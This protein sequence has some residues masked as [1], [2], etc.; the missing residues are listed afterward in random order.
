MVFSAFGVLTRWVAPALT[1]AAVAATAVT[2]GPAPAVH[3][4]NDDNP[5]A[6]RPF[7][8]DPVSAAMNAHNARE[9]LDKLLSLSG[10]GLLLL[11]AVLVAPMAAMASGFTAEADLD[12]T[13]S[14]FMTTFTVLV[15]IVA[16]PVLL[17]ALS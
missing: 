7:Y 10:L 14:T 15:A 11:T 9:R 4:V 8:V 1:L 5:L 17:V 6:G 13:V 16:M 3:L 12:V 2:T